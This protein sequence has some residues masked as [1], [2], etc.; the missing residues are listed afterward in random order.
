[1][2]GEVPLPP[3]RDLKDPDEKRR[4]IVWIAISFIVILAT[5]LS[6]VLIFGY[7][8]LVAGMTYDEVVLLTGLGLLVFCTILYLGAREREQRAANKSL[9]TQLRGAVE[10]LDER[11]EQ[12]NGLCSASAELAGSLDLDHATHAVVESVVG[13]LNAEASYLILVDPETARPVYARSCP[14][15]SGA[16]P[17]FS[18][19]PEIGWSDFLPMAP[20][21]VEDFESK[22]TAWNRGRTTMR[23]TLRLANGLVGIL[24][25]RRSDS[26]Q[27]FTKDDL[28]ILTTL[29]NMAAKALESAQ[30][31]EELR[32]SYLATVRSLV[33]SLHARDNYTA[34]HSE[35]VAA[36]AVNMGEYLGLPDRMIRDIEVFGPLHDVGKIGIRDSVL[37]K[38][39]PLSDEERLLCREHCVIGEQI[40]RPLRPSRHALG[41]VRNHHESWDGGGYPDGLAGEEI[42]QLARL[43]QAADCYD[44]MIT[45]RPYQPAMSEQ[46]VLAH[47]RQYNAKLYD[48]VVVNALCAVVGEGRPHRSSQKDAVREESAYADAEADRGLHLPVGWG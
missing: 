9:V 36:L 3:F 33:N 20:M 23:A 31:H 13:A 22:I 12:L 34:S 46:E 32:R 45:D 10:S 21:D 28:R 6:V 17:D 5:W 15:V 42:P 40:L 44:A 43:L 26:R 30:L 11:V 35:R 14:T 8:P 47:L 18:L 19:D 41:M 7:Q 24:G 38:S 25:A 37:M 29:A 1:L 4:E 27:H 16:S 39:G 48:P 2:E